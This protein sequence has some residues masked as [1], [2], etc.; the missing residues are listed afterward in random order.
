MGVRLYQRLVEPVLALALR[1]KRLTALGLDGPVH[2]IAIDWRR[3]ADCREPCPLV[4]DPVPRLIERYVSPHAGR[5]ERTRL[6]PMVIDLA[7]Y[8][9]A[10]AFDATLKARSSRTLP[11]I[12][13]AERAGY[14]A[15]PFLI[16]NHVYDVHAIRTS[17]RMRSA[18]PVL[19]YWLLKPEH[20]AEPATELYRFGWPTC[21]MHWIIW[22]GVFLPEPGYKQGDVVVGERLVAFVKMWRMGDIGHYTEIMGHKDH[23]DQGVMHLLH[24]AITQ[25]AIAG[26]AEAMR[27]MRVLLYGALEHGRLGLLTWKKRGGFRA[28]R[29]VGVA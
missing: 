9:D 3:P 17:M 10:K 4:K 26:E 29:L 11:K 15:R 22:W 24:R 1:R 28:A 6:M 23:L 18:G 8:P 13:K 7:D 16:Q 14:I 19:D 12:R 20:I 25:A 27:G 21:P 2:E 5:T